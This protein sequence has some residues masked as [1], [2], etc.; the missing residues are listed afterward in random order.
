MAVRGGVRDCG[1]GDRLNGRAM[2]RRSCTDLSRRSRDRT[3]DCRPEWENFL[4]VYQGSPERAARAA[5]RAR[6]R[7]S[8]VAPTPATQH[9]RRLARRAGSPMGRRMT[10]GRFPVGW[11]AGS[12]PGRAATSPRGVGEGTPGPPAAA[13]RVAGLRLLRLRRGRS[14]SR[15][16]VGPSAACGPGWLRWGAIPPTV[17]PGKPSR[18]PPDPPASVRAVKAVLTWRA[19]RRPAPPVGGSTADSEDGGVGRRVGLTHRQTDGCCPHPDSSA[20]SVAPAAACR[21]SGVVT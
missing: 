16:A 19:G 8:A 21:R 10:T 9:A 18:P 7:R 3:A 6:V 13:G 20:S 14:G 2:S 1:L 12:R 17:D 15:M 5:A 4:Y 11:W